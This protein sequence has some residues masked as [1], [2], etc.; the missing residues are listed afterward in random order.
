MKTVNMIALLGPDITD[1]HVKLL[2]T[3][4]NLRWIGIDQA[5]TS[6]AGIAALKA[7]NPQATIDVYD[8]ETTPFER[9]R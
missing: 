3:M 8:A 7:A 9:Q 6:E 4:P 5:S 1:A 2:E